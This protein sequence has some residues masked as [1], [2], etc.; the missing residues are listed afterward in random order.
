[1]LNAL[2]GAA[3]AALPPSP[4]VAAAA[5]AAA[6]SA[7]AA[8]AAETAAIA[9]ACSAFDPVYFAPLMRHRLLPLVAAVAA[10]PIPESQIREGPYE[11]PAVVLRRRND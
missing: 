6:A 5:A 10:K 2:A 4:F 3:A 7:A 1:M 9:Q 11:S 8:A